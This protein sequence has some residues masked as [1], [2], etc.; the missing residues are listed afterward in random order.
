MT[1]NPAVKTDNPAEHPADRRFDMRARL[2]HATLASAV[3]LGGAAAGTQAPPPAAA[4]GGQAPATGEPPP[5]VEQMRRAVSRLRGNRIAVPTTYD[6]LTAEQQAYVKSIL[7]GPRGDISGPLAVMMV[8]PGLG[9]LSQ[10]AMA[11]ARFAGRDGFA[12]VPPKLNELAILMV[13]KLWS[14]NYVW[15]AHHNYAVQVGLPRDV[16][17]AV[18]AGRRPARMESDVAAVYTFCDEFLNARKVS[19]AALQAAK[20][21]LGGDRGVVDLV[22]T[23]GLYQITAMMVTLDQTPLPDGVKPF[24]P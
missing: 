19:G 20:D 15:N 5:T 6:T 18:L 4:A 3:L 9:D 2:L 22:G 24:F 7:T 8:S 1:H 21:V 10:K 16:V 13:A 23:M 11:Y 14:A 17:D 12:A